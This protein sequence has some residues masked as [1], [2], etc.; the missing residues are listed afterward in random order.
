MRQSELARDEILTSVIFRT[1]INSKF[2]LAKCW[3]GWNSTIENATELLSFWNVWPLLS[4][5][6]LPK[7][8]RTCNAEQS[9]CLVHC[10]T[11]RYCWMPVIYIVIFHPRTQVRKNNLTCLLYQEIISW[12]Y[13][14]CKIQCTMP[15]GGT[16]ECSPF[17]WSHLKRA[18]SR[19]IC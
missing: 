5:S 6:N 18:V 11:G 8:E 16:A 13:P 10:T 1:E 9:A 3:N 4:V 7:L 17:P 15:Q 2:D 14:T 12:L 19:C